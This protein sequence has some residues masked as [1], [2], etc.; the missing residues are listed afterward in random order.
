MPETV[1]LLILSTIGATESVTGLGTAALTLEVAGTT[2]SVASLVGSA[3]IIGVSIG[4][5]YALNNPNVPKPEN[6]AQPLKQAVPARQRGY[7]INRLGGYYMLFLAAGGDSQDVIAFH[8]G[9]IERALQVYFHDTPVA[10]SDA[11]D[12]QRYVTVIPPTG[13]NFENVNLQI[14]YGTA[15]QNSCD[16]SVNASNTSGVWT[17]SFAGKGIACLC[18]NCGHAHDPTEFTKIYPQGLPLPSVIA[19]CAPIWDPRDNAQSA[20]DPSTWKASPNPVLQL[21]DYLTASDGGM[22]EDLDVILPPA[23][24]AQWMIEASLCADNLAGRRRYDS[25]GFYQFDN[26]PENVINKILATCDGWLSEDGDG[27]LVLVVGYYREPLEPPLTS[28]H[29][30]GWSWRKGQADEE[31]INQ[32]DVTFTNPSLGYVT[33]QTPPVRDEAAISAAGIV[34][35][36]PLDLSWVQNADQAAALGQRAMLRLNPKMAGSLVTTLYGM[37]YLGK[38]WVKLQLPAVKGL[39]DCIIE[40]QDKGKVDLLNGRVTFN[41][42]LVDPSQLSESIALPKMYREDGSFLVREDG[43]VYTRESV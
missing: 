33:D 39:E 41:W 24:L 2:V 26:S 8:S 32:L 3:A 4:L 40:I 12:H 29:I 37:R 36:K 17:S 7:W 42:I 15:T 28:D 20:S 11:L 6:G 1:G 22:G 5:Q 18:M 9:P 14:F 13:I 25:A 30:L 10:T 43:S 31:S 19:R 23:V 38:R 16:V 27:S 35:S 21:I 34:R